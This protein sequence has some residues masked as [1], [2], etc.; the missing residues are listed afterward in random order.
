MLP[1]LIHDDLNVFGSSNEK[2]LVVR[3]NNGFALWNNWPVASK[4]GSNPGIGLGQQ[5]ANG[6]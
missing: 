1:K 6:L 5:R 2:D 4:D 3:R